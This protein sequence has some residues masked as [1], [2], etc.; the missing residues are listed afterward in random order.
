MYGSTHTAAA[1]R[2]VRQE[3][4]RAEAGDRPGTKAHIHMFSSFAGEMH[5]AITII[6]YVALFYFLLK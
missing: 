3:L 4:F 1:L 5:H 6:Q 2:R